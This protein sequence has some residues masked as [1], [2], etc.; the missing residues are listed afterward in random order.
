MDGDRSEGDICT[1][2]VQQNDLT[3]AELQKILRSVVVDAVIVL[4]MPSEK[5]VF[6]SDIRFTTS[7]THWSGAFS[8]LRVDAVQTEATGVAERMARHRLARTTRVQL[9]D[10]SCP[11]AVL[12]RKQWAIACMISRGLPVQDL[13]WQCGLALYEAVEAV[14]DLIR[15]GMC[16]PEPGPD[17]VIRRGP[18]AFAPL[19]RR[20]PGAQIAQ[21]QYRAE[22]EFSTGAAFWTPGTQM[23]HGGEFG[24][25][26][27]EL[28]HRVLDGVK[29]I[30]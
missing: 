25:A 20:T 21:A 29:N 16:A 11:S 8:R 6:V 1:T 13:A 19:P 17:P 5:D 4:T 22:A 10:L 15:A 3:V 2:L 26:P 9:R 12:N 7:G 30:S 23:P 18:G 24:P 28:L 14:G 27:A